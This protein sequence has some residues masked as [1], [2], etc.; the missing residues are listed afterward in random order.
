MAI[1]WEKDCKDTMW[2]MFWL[3]RGISPADQAQD[4]EALK[5]N[6]ARLIRMTTQKTA[7]QR[8][9]AGDIDWDSLTP[10]LMNIAISATALCLNGTFGEMPKE[11]DE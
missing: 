9:K 7:G 5:A 4:A 10:T 2:A 1:D 3:G 6:V 11:I 8:G